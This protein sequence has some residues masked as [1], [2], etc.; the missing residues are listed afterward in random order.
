[1]SEAQDLAVFLG[2][3][4]R[5]KTSLSQYTTVVLPSSFALHLLNLDSATDHHG[6]PQPATTQP[7]VAGTPGQP[8]GMSI[9]PSSAAK[10]PNDG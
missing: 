1:M 4:T 10:E 8:A 3:S 7:D 5:F 2:G 6:I 9:K